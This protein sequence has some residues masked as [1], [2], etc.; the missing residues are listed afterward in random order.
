VGDVD[1]VDGAGAAPRHSGVV[2]LV[3]RHSGVAVLVS[4]HSGVAVLAGVLPLVALLVLFN[5][6]S[7]LPLRT[8]VFAGFSSGFE[9]TS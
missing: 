1:G 7:T 8:A 4:R 5:T 9:P 6:K 2:A 3:S